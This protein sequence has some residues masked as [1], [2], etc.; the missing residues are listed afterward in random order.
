MHKLTTQRGAIPVE[1]DRPRILFFD[2]AATALLVE[3]YGM[4]FAGELYTIRKVPTG[5]ECRLKDVHALAF[6][7]FAGLQAEARAIGQPLTLEQVQQHIH[8][9]SVPQLFDLTLRGLTG[10]VATPVQPGKSV[11]AAKSPKRA[12]KKAPAKVK[13]AAAPKAAKQ[14]P[15]PAKKAPKQAAHKVSTLKLRGGLRLER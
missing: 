3:R 5:A 14:A 6:F 1:L 10:Q 7:L 2:M 11:A 4:H 12:A 15:K 9:W 13:P 8:P